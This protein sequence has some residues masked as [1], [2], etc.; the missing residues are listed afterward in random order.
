[1]ARRLAPAQ[2]VQIQPV[3]VIGGDHGEAGEA[4][5]RR[6]GLQDAG[7]AGAA[8]DVKQAQDHPSILRWRSG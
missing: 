3:A 8:A 4:A 1:M 2:R 5:L 6:L 7:Q